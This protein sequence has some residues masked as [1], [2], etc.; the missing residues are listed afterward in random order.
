MIVSM[1]PFKL[2][3]GSVADLG[4]VFAKHQILE[5]A[6]Q[7]EGC[8]TLVLATPD[9]EGDEAYVIGLWDDDAAYQRWID[10]ENRGDATED[11]L[12]LVAG[13]FDPSAPAG[14]WQVLR[15]R[16]DADLAPG[17]AGA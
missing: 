2:K 9:I 5:T 8:Q 10:H 11:L 17:A 15:A 3:S 4:D 14:Q 12:R 13:D 1:L 7:V 6:I 16:Y